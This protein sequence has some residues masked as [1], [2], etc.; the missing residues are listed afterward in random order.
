MPSTPGV[1]V[2]VPFGIASDGGDNVVEKKAPLHV[3]VTLD[4]PSSIVSVPSPLLTDIDPLFESMVSTEAL[5]V[6]GTVIPASTPVPEQF[7]GAAVNTPLLLLI[8]FG[9]WQ[10]KTPL[11]PG[12]VPLQ[13]RAKPLPLVLTWH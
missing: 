8:A 6:P 3:A 5:K 13:A 11:P 2:Q 4:S 12:I 7:T 10:F 9:D 1:T